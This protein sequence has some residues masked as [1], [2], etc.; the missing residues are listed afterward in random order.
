MSETDLT[1]ASFMFLLKWT[2]S[3]H[4]ASPC[5]RSLLPNCTFTNSSLKQAHWSPDS[6]ILFADLCTRFPDHTCITLWPCLS[7]P[8]TFFSNFFFLN[9]FP[10]N[11]RSSIYCNI[12]L[13]IL[14]YNNHPLSCN[15]HIQFD[16][17]FIMH[18]GKC[19][20]T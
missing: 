7:W 5:P 10:S 9:Y 17:Y 4:K 18:K 15:T 19:L 16:W 13:C 11:L 3:D 1:Q 2:L 6:T 8:I 20:S 12:H 14:I